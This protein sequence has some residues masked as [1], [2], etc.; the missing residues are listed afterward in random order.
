MDQIFAAC[1]RSSRAV[2]QPLCI[3]DLQDGTD[4]PQNAKSEIPSGA[5]HTLSR[6]WVAG[7]MASVVRLADFLTASAS[8]SGRNRPL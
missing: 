2:K 1:T 8:L 7:R 3:S 4:I 5:N 6:S